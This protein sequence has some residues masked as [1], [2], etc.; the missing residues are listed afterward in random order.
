MEYAA[1][2]AT[3][4]NI[5]AGGKAAYSGAVYAN[6]KCDELGIDKGELAEKSGK[7]LWGAISSAF[8]SDPKK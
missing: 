3:A 6:A 1:Q 2:Y 8:S 4:E 7:T 5:E